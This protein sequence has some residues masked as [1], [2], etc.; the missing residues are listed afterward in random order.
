MGGEQ[1]H[2][3]SDDR[4]NET[5]NNARSVDDR[6]SQSENLQNVANAIQGD[7]E[8]SRMCGDEFILKNE[9]R[10][11]TQ[12]KINL[13]NSKVH[14][15]QAQ[16][17]KTYY[18][19]PDKYSVFKGWSD[20]AVPFY[21]EYKSSERKLNVVMPVKF[22]G[23]SRRDENFRDTFKNAYKECVHRVW[24]GRHKLLLNS[25][26]SE[27]N[28]SCDTW[29]NIDPVE[30]EVYVDDKSGYSKY[31]KIYYKDSYIDK[32]GKEHHYRD[33]TW[34]DYVNFSKDTLEREMDDQRRVDEQCVFAHEFGHQI[35][36]DDEYLIDYYHGKYKGKVIKGVYRN[37]KIKAYERNPGCRLYVLSK[38]KDG[39]MF[40]HEGIDYS[41]EEVSFDIGGES[42]KGYVLREFNSGKELEKPLNGLESESPVEAVDRNKKT[43][44]AVYFD[45][46]LR[47]NENSGLRTY[48]LSKIRHKGAS[49]Y[50]NA[51]KYSVHKHEDED[52]HK[53]F[54]YLV[55][56]ASGRRR[57][58][59]LDGSYT[60]HTE[61]AAEEFGEEYAMKNATTRKSAYTITND[62]V[63]YLPTNDLMNAGN[64]FEPH[65]YIPFKKGMVKA[66]QK[67]YTDVPS[68]KA[69]NDEKDWKIE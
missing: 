18:K 51:V 34:I 27:K 2:V 28:E 5:S 31:Y 32:N 1:T 48:D 45:E 35:G 40:N 59:W 17:Y 8:V 43:H 37:K 26:N 6:S 69:P 66:I 46:N 42:R 7:D 56:R 21:V 39:K 68:Q 62:T 36:L 44:K 23:L 52:S 33:D 65:Y 38:D 47:A 19:L 49:L 57:G 3:T 11:K 20:E 25:V 63:K 54:Y 61:M 58:A 9:N 24:S 41:A 4:E 53:D 29:A 12:K 64:V 60:T 15:F 30:V 14:D 67:K 22:K 10:S 16:T 13:L 55:D 50:H